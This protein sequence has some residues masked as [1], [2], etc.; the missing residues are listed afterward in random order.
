MEQ[1]NFDI[2]QGSTFT[3]DVKIVDASQVPVNLTGVTFAGQIRKTASSGAV[4]GTFTFLT[5][6]ADLQ[7][8]K[9]SMTLNATE[10]SALPCD[11]SPSA[12]RAITQ[13]AYDVEI[14]Y[15]DGIVERILSG[16][17]KVSPEVTR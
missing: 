14:T 15:P 11:C 7:G 2:D 10:T 9:F 12:V 5:N 17:L 13:L 16:I 6:P 1:T 8:G 3:V 4:L